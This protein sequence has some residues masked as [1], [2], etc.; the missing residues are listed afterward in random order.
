VHWGEDGTFS[1]ERDKAGGFAILEGPPT[2]PRFRHALS[3]ERF[4][5][6]GGQPVDHSDGT[7]TGIRTCGKNNGFTLTA[8]A[9][10]K[11]RVL[12]LYVGIIA[13]KGRLSAKLSAGSATS[14]LTLEQ[15][16]GT[17]RT[18]VL[19]ISYRAPRAAKLQLSWTTLD[20]FGTGCGGVALQA[21]TL[22]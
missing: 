4:A 22:R 10:E 11:T 21:A 14:G 20:S 2:A 1:L 9:A 8:P 15:R 12:K 13:G 19:T 7:P 18:A 5:W 3:P 6:Q 16:D 17:F